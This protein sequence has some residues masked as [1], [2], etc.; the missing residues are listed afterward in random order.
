MLLEEQIRK[1][2]H[3]TYLLVALFVL[4]IAGIGFLFGMGWGFPSVGVGVALALAAVY[5]LATLGLS[6]QLIAKAVNGR[7]MGKAEHPFFSGIRSRA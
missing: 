4:I 3:K 6:K 2:N 1:N 5:C 7:P